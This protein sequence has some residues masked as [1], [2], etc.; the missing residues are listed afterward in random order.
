MHLLERGTN[1]DLG[2]LIRDIERETQMRR[3]HGLVCTVCGNEITDEIFMTTIFGR[4]RHR[5]VNPH[6]IEYE[7]SVFSEAPGCNDIDSPT[8]ENTWF[9]GFA[10]NIT[11]CGRCTEHLG[12]HFISPGADSFYGLI[13]TKLAPLDDD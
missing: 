11:L 9:E 10:W 7:F 8:R 13:T 3:R 6:G 5:R 12:W 4:H 1:D 2:A